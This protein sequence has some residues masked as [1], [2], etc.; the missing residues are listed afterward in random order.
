[1][2][3]KKLQKS[4]KPLKPQQKPR[5]SVVIPVYKPNPEIFKRVKEMLIKQ[6]IKPEILE[7]W[8]NPEAVSMNKGIKK[9]KGEIVITLAQDCLPHGKDW[10]EKLISPLEDKNIV[11]SVSDLNLPEDFWRK[12]YNN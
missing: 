7:I 4:I 1:M 8:N 2:P 6:T 9:A 11:V 10:L 12:E 3:A 5:V